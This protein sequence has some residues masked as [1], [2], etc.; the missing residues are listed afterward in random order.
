MQPET[1]HEA[2]AAQ[3]RWVGFLPLAGIAAVAL[4]V[5]GFVVIESV[6]PTGTPTPD[7]LLTYFQD[8]S[9]TVGMA[10]YATMLGSLFFLAFVAALWSRLSAAEGRSGPLAALALAAGTV[11]A[12]SQLFLYGS[13]LDAAAASVKHPLS[14]STAEAYYYLGD[15][16]FVGAMLTAALMLASTGILALRTRLLPS[17]LAWTSLAIALPLLLP[18][19]GPPVMFLAF[20]AWIVVVAIALSLPRSRPRTTT[21]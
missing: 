7:E 15:F 11:T 1:T 12:I 21:P 19:I 2:T 5:V 6:R 3:P 13:D 8:N 18:P 9:D 20:P 16:W 4:W 14:A 17:W 10:I